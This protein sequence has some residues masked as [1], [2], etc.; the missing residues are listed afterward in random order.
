MGVVPPKEQDVIR[1]LKLSVSLDP[2]PQG[3]GE[4][5]E[6]ELINSG[7]WCNQSQ[8][9]NVKVIQSGPTLC[10]PID[11][12]VHGML[13]ARILEWVAVPFS[14]GSSQPRNQ[15][16]V[17]CI[18]GGL[19]TNWAIRK[20]PNEDS[21]KTLNDR[22]QRAHRLVGM[23]KC[24][25]S[26]APGKGMEVL[27]A[28]PICCATCLSH[29]VVPELYLKCSFYF[30]YL[31]LA[32]PH[33]TWD[34]G[35][36]TRSQTCTSYWKHGVLTTGLQGSIPWAVKKWG[37]KREREKERSNFETRIYNVPLC[38]LINLALIFAMVQA[39][40]I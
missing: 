12:T 31:F 34:L 32:S 2:G 3:K 36:P 17:S 14:K 35:S 30:I 13:Q 4:G 7:Q 19:F 15:T 37:K 23:S 8:L 40:P 11:Y 38:S 33:D 39:C 20:A 28:V 5:P 16:M 27:H 29:L 21:I 25:E 9:C 18:A 6:I 26:G 24:W 22:V 1:Q 10:N